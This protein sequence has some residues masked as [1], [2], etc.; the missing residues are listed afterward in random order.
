ML[1]INVLVQMCRCTYVDVLVPG[2]L[3]GTEAPVMI[4]KGVD[5]SFLF[6]LAMFVAACMLD[7]LQSAPCCFVKALMMMF[8]TSVMLFAGTSCSF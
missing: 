4:P 7:Q 8:M 2:L 1:S 6:F 5:F 3:L